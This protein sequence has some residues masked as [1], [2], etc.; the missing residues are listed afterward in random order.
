MKIAMTATGVTMISYLIDEYAEED[1][2]QENYKR[3]HIDSG[4]E[5]R[6]PGGP[7]KEKRVGDRIKSIFRS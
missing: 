6:A 7:I 1:T 5:P 2:V 4:G 3:D